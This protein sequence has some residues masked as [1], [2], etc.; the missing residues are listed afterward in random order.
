MLSLIFAKKAKENAQKTQTT[1]EGKKT[2]VQPGS[3]EKPARPPPIDRVQKIK[4]APTKAII[5]VEDRKQGETVQELIDSMNKNMGSLRSRL[6]DMEHIDANLKLAEI[7]LKLAVGESEEAQGKLSGFVEEMEGDFKLLEKKPGWA[8]VCDSFL[9][10][11]LGE[12]KEVPAT[13]AALTEYLVDCVRR[14]DPDMKG[15]KCAVISWHPASHEMLKVFAASDDAEVK[16]GANLR[17]NSQV[18]TAQLAWQV[19]KSGEY[20][21]HNPHGL[22]KD[23]ADAVA[24]VPLLTIGGN[25]FGVIVQGPPALPDEFLSVISRQAGPLL[26]RVWKHEKMLQAV[27]N[28]VS[29]IKDVSLDM[30]QLVYVSF[31]E[32]ATLPKD[33]E[34]EAWKWQ[35]LLYHPHGLEKFEYE[36]K[37]KRGESIG[38]L[39]VS[40]GTFTE[41]CAPPPLP[42]RRRATSPTLPRRS[43]MPTAR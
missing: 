37:W 11:A 20:I 42:E 31:K 18:E 2:R 10:A 29:F 17:E 23:A 14:G 8:K 16:A 22:D 19:I 41:M 12:N 25:A 40:C 28:T 35:P 34:E 21:L 9:S 27:Q 39:T 26:E 15:C 7:D 13:T 38:V 30:H 4:R 5:Q 3:P 24:V 6:M 36:V 33:E 32:G 1:A 43:A